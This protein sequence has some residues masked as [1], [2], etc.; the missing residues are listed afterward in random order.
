M[1]S[2]KYLLVRW[3][4]LEGNKKN[5]QLIKVCQ[6]YLAICSHVYQGKRFTHPQYWLKPILGGYQLLNIPIGISI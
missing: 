4:N 3:G 1:V 6:F 5:Y 2:L